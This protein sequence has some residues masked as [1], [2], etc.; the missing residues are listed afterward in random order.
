MALHIWRNFRADLPEDWELLQ[1]SRNPAEGRCAFADRYD[2]R[3]ELSWREVPGPPDFD[4][5]MSDYEAKL[6]EQGADS[7]R[8]VKVGQWQGL[9]ARNN[10]S[11]SSRYGRYF[12][13][14]SCLI[15][16]VFPWPDG[17]QDR[18]LAARILESISAEHSPV[19]GKRRW[20]AFGMDFLVSDGLALEECSFLPGK[21]EMCF[22]DP[23]EGTVERFTRLGMVGDWLK[24][25][26][27]D[28][29]RAQ[30]D[31]RDEVTRRETTRV[32]DHAVEQ[33]RLTHTRK[34][35][36]KVHLR[37]RKSE[38]AAWICPATDRLYF[39]RIQGKP[40]KGEEN[41]AAADRLACCAA[42]ELG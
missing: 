7:T 37:R 42:K 26:V 30:F 32:R 1:F 18:R 34:G 2:F 25:T 29:L 19:E 27:A 38:A 12:P 41:T 40:G 31:V 8:R 23:R 9:E 14:E 36:N 3:F 11:P 39:V 20:C 33:I 35:A 15:E 28:W 17:R 21:A 16:S 24:G 22:T 10:G 5:M 13:D 6:K 4:R